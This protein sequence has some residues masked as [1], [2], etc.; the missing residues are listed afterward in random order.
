M[1]V[2]KFFSIN[3]DFRKA[4]S[5]KEYTSEQVEK[6]F[7]H[8]IAMDNFM[9][10]ALKNVTFVAN[11]IIAGKR[12]EWGSW[13]FANGM[14]ELSKSRDA[15]QLFYDLLDEAYDED[16]LAYAVES[17]KGIGEVLDSKVKLIKAVQAS[18]VSETPKTL[19]GDEF[20]LRA[21]AVSGD[22]AILKKVLR[23][24]KDEL[25]DKEYS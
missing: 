21:A 11:D 16:D 7:S 12:K 9:A 19:V 5:S 13:A 17:D 25:S 8:I 23:L 6:A 1:N 22:I 4:E 20:K 3:F 14:D 24:L 10:W 2:K 18:F 15:E